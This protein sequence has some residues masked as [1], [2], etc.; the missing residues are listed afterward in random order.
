MKIHVGL[1][2]QMHAYKETDADALTQR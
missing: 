1:R 2:K